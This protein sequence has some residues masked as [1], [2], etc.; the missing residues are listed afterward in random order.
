MARALACPKHVRIGHRTYTIVFKTGIEL[1][2]FPCNGL[3]L[4]DQ[5]ELHIDASLKPD[6]MAEVVWHECLHAMHWEAGLTDSSGEEEYTS[7]TAKALVRFRQDNK[8]LVKWLD[9]MAEPPKE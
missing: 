1:E 7:L 8:T 6:V 9:K 5:S 2:G 4:Y 3:C